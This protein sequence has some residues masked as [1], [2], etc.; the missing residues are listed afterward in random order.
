MQILCIETQS[1][2]TSEVKKGTIYTSLRIF[3]TGVVY[4]GID[5]WHKIEEINPMDDAH[6][7][8]FIDLPSEEGQ[9]FRKEETV[10]IPQKLQP[11]YS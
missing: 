6:I 1:N 9:S 4:R 10:E 3:P 5:R 7:S 11:Y 8:L 2:S